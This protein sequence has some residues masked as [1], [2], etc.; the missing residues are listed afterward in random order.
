MEQLLDIYGDRIHLSDRLLKQWTFFI[1]LCVFMG[2]ELL[3]SLRC[4]NHMIYGSTELLAGQTL[5]MFEISC[6]KKSSVNIN[7]NQ[8]LKEMPKLAECTILSVLP[9][10]PLC[11]R[12]LNDFY[13]NF[14]ER[15]DLICS[16]NQF[17]WF[18]MPQISL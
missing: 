2:T 14:H 4:N 17:S 9:G 3:T 7:W 10:L 6:A 11:E 1:Y 18:I 13:R 5:L 15:N 12:D 8:C 16:V